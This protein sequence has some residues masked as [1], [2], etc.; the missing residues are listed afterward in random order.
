MAKYIAYRMGCGSFF[1]ILKILGCYE[2]VK[3]LFLYSIFAC[4]IVVVI[5]G[6]QYVDLSRSALDGYAAQVAYVKD[7]IAEGTLLDQP[8]LIWVHVIR[9]IPAAFSCVLY[10]LG[11]AALVGLGMSILFVPILE[12]FKTSKYP[13]FVVFFPLVLVIFSYR[14]ALVALSIGYL[15]LFFLVRRRRWYLLV[16]FT[17]ANLSSGGVLTII[18]MACFMWHRMRVRSVYLY[19]FVCLLFISL[20]VS[21]YDKIY[22]F[23][24][25]E[26]GYESTISGVSGF[27][28]IFTRSTIIVSFLSENYMRGFVYSGF[29]VFVIFILIYAS[30]KSSLRPYLL[31]ISIALPSFLVEGLGVVTLLVP[32]L[33][34]LSQ[35]GLP[36]YCSSVPVVSSRKLG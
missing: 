5:S 21:L 29:L 2:C 17:F 10:E 28:A 6:K 26:A 16:S 24:A 3:L 4:W 34:L 14:A 12:L 35:R 32:V 27:L 25:G 9:A 33:M 1:R 13:I 31:L 36:A 7:I 23:I 8:L 11:G 19:L 18:F 15:M 20:F 22:G 30:L